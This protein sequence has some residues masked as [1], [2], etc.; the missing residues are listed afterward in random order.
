MSDKLTFAKYVP[1]DLFIKKDETV[2]IWVLQNIRRDI[3]NMTLFYDKTPLVND[4]RTDQEKYTDWWKMNK[5]IV[6]ETIDKHIAEY[7]GDK[8]DG[9]E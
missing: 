1:D 3:D 5:A 9:N 7:T 6:I 2:P 4:T 8:E